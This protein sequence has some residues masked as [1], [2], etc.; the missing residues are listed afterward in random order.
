MKVVREHLQGILKDAHAL[1]Q[2]LGSNPLGQ[3]LGSVAQQASGLNQVSQQMKRTASATQQLQSTLRPVRDEF[4]ALRAEAHNIDFGDLTDTQQFK[5]AEREIDSY[6][7]SLKR[8]E[9]QVDK[10]SPQGRELA[11]QLQ[12]QQT[13]ASNR[14]G[15]ATQERRSA[16]AQQRQGAA[17]A[18]AA[19]GAAVM[20]PI[21]SIGKEAISVTA[22]F[23]DQ[24]AAIKAVLDPKDWGMLDA[25]RQKSKDLGAS[26]RFSASDAA[27][28]FVLLAQ[29]GY[30]V[31]KQMAAITGTL[32]L[33]AAGNLELTRA[34]EITVST[35]GQFQLEADRATHVAN[36]LAKAAAMGQIDVNDMGESLKYTGGS[37]KRANL[38][39]EQTSALLALL[40][41]GGLK[42][43]M[44]GSN[45]GSLIDSLTAPNTLGAK[46]I[47]ELGV[48]TK[49]ARGNLL[50]FEQ[51]LGQVQARISKLPT[52]KQNNLMSR[53]FGVTGSRAASIL[54]PRFER[55]ATTT[56][57]I[58][59]SA[60]KGL[61]AA[62]DQATIME[63]DIGGSFRSFQSAMEGVFIE[64]GEVLVPI[65][66]AA[67]D[68][69][70]ALLG[71]FISLPKPIKTAIVAAGLVTLGIATLAIVVGTA[72]F[73]FFG[74]Q[75]A[76][77]QSAIAMTAMASKGIPLTGF[78]A[79]AM[80][81]FTGQGIV[82]GFGALATG[83][84]DAAIALGAFATGPL[85]LAIGAGIAIIALLEV[86]T[87]GFNVLGTVI[88]AVLAPVAVIFGVIKG[89]LQGLAVAFKP[90]LDE[91]KGLGGTG[92]YLNDVFKTAIATFQTFI[93]IGQAVGSALGLVL[94]VVIATPIRLL[95][96]LFQFLSTTLSGLGTI[97]S[98]I[99]NPFVGAA[100]QIRQAWQGFVDWFQAMP[101]VQFALTVGQGLINALNH[102]PTIV[103]PASWQGAIDSI[104][105]F[106]KPLMDFAQQT[107]QFLATVLNPGQL[108]G[109]LV[110]GLV[111][112]L[113]QLVQAVQNSGVGK[114]FWGATES[115]QAFMTQ[116][117]QPLTVPITAQV[118]PEQPERYPLAT[119]PG[120][121]PP[122]PSP[123]A[124]LPVSPVSAAVMPDLLMS[125]PAR[126]IQTEMQQAIAV[127][128]LQAS[129]GINQSFDTI[130]TEWRQ[131]WSYLRATGNTDAA[132]LFQP[133]LTA[134]KD[135]LATVHGA[136]GSTITDMA[137]A[138]ATLD[139][140]KAK[141]SA[142]TLGTTL[143]VG[144]DAAGA[145]MG[146][147]TLSAMVL[148]ASSL[149][150]L[151]P[152]VLLLGGVAL[153]ALAISTNFLGIRT[154]LM[155]IVKIVQGAIEIVRGLWASFTAI[156]GTVI[157][158]GQGIRQVFGGILPALQGDFSGIR[159][160]FST[161]LG[162]MQAGASATAQGIR[163]SFGGVARIFEGVGQVGRGVFVGLRQ[164]VQGVA[165]AISLAFRSARAGVD[166]FFQGVRLVANGFQRLQTIP[167]LVAGMGD[168]LQATWQGLSQ[169]LNNI[170]ILR[171]FVSLVASLPTVVTREVSRIQALWSG[172][173]DR[174][175]ATWQGT[176][177]TINNIPVL[178]GFIG[179]V[180]AFPGQ[181]GGVLQK[182]Q[183]LWSGMSDRLTAIWQGTV[184][185]L[186][187]IP[188]LRGLVA[189]LESLP[190]LV[191]GTVERVQATWHGAITALDNVPVLRGFVTF[192]ETLP[193][194]VSGVI[195][196]VQSL[197]S[198]MGDRLGSVFGFLQGKSKQTGE[199]L[200]SN[201][202]ENSPGPTFMIRQKWSLLAEVLEGKLAAIAG[203]A[204]T[205]G[206]KITGSLSGEKI[207]QGVSKLGN[208][209]SSVG[210][211]L[212]NFAPQLAGPLFLVGDIASSFDTLS[213]TLPGAQKLLAKVGPQLQSL[214]GAGALIPG[215]LGTIGTAFSGMATTAIAAFGSVLLPILPVLAVIAGIVAAV[216]LLRQAFK[217]NFL[218][219]RTLVMGV[220]G[221]ISQIA[222]TMIAPFVF[223][224]QMV[225]QV[226]KS[227]IDSIAGFFTSLLDSARQTGQLILNVLNPARLFQP[228]I[229]GLAS[230]LQQLLDAISN[231]G[232]G[233]VLNKLG[234]GGLTDGLQGFVG[235]L[236]QGNA[237]VK[238]IAKAP[239]AP[240]TMTS[241]TTIAQ[242]LVQGVQQGVS[243]AQQVATAG[244]EQISHEWR[245]HWSELDQPMALPAPSVNQWN[246]I[247]QPVNVVLPQTSVGE[248]ATVKTQL[249]AVQG[250]AGLLAQ[251]TEAA[252]TQSHFDG[253]KQSVSSFGEVFTQT[254]HGILG[255]FRSM[256]LGAIVF[257]VSSLLSVSP[258]I[259]ILGGMVLATIALATNFLGLRTILVGVGRV[260]VG[261][262]Q[263]VA[264]WIRGTAGVVQGLGNLIGGVFAAIRGDFS[265][266]RL[267]ATQV[268]HGIKTVFT[269]TATGLQT[270]F[271]GAIQIIKGLFQG[272]GQVVQ[273]IGL[274]LKGIGGT[275]QL[276][277][278]TLAGAIALPQKIW[279][280]FF[281]LLER[282]QS[283]V[284]GVISAVQNSSVGK[285][286]AAV[287]I[288]TQ[289]KAGTMADAVQLAEF[290]QRLQSDQTPAVSGQRRGL[291]GRLFGRKELAGTAN[292]IAQPIVIPAPSVPVSLS[293]IAPT[294]PLPALVQPIAVT[295]ATVAPTA[296]AA[297]IEQGQR[298]LQQ[299]KQQRQEAV[300]G[301]STSVSALGNVASLMAP[302]IAA[303]VMAA[304][305]LFDSFVSLG[306]AIPQVTM[307][308]GGLIPG[309]LGTGTAAVTAG[310]Q[311]ATGAAIGSTATATGA[312]VVAGANATMGFSFGA[313]AT[314]AG[315][316]WTAITGPLLPLLLG[317]G[318]AVAAVGLLWKAFDSNFLGI[319][320]TVM[321]VWQ[322]ITQIVGDVWQSF[323]GIFSSL[324]EAVTQVGSAIASAFAPLLGNGGGGAMQ[325]AIKAMLFPL[326]VVSTVLKVIFQI[327]GQLIRVV[328]T[329]L[330]PMIQ[331]LIFPVRLAA[332][333]L[334]GVFTTISTIAGAVSSIFGGIM[335][336]VG[337]VFQMLW[338]ALPAPIRWLIQMASQGMGAIGSFVFGA[339]NAPQPP[340]I[341][342]FAAGGLVQ[343]PG[344]ATSDSIPALLSNHEYVMPADVTQRNLGTLEAM[345]SGA[346]IAAQPQLMPL[347]LPPIPP[348]TPTG[349]GGSIEI[350]VQA[351][352]TIEGGLTVQGATP[353]LAAEDLVRQVFDLAGPML[354]Q[355]VVDAM[356]RRVEMA[357]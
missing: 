7:Q 202:A 242:P 344:T 79:N 224:A 159:Q 30:D 124:P 139:F 312:G 162:A 356:R 293:S 81:A 197:W 23:N 91:F 1:K 231:S 112:R 45:L 126:Q 213:E 237:A 308:L 47:Q 41:E 135:S 226:W 103:I 343:G 338:S 83:I 199:A 228:L 88:G 337:S 250:E 43:E 349:G 129:T 116:L 270:V 239:I 32:N 307:L 140:E 232:L 219:I 257:G 17:G 348:L 233:A 95:I 215:L 246:P 184:N 99:A 294:Q 247:E 282:V 287:G 51:I 311:Q 206:Q 223:A 316:A 28:G 196:K 193:P 148:G 314:A 62:K 318:L 69:L 89:F 13:I 165:T 39:L 323:S 21:V 353:T 56:Q 154:I 61:G 36:V 354:E 238:E 110:E 214:R 240:P 347:P 72:S 119:M 189:F 285:M 27:S 133:G 222:T 146:S 336:T 267:G 201:L 85:G 305:T 261:L 19:G 260:A 334:Q 346:T 40:S 125:E 48:Q 167:S 234:L 265:Q 227:G 182:V 241:A 185:A 10:T 37:A 258:L 333:I 156:V 82:A 117:S 63:G 60:D 331:V 87:P 120:N 9:T 210:V 351:P 180:E 243:Q 245:N 272:L 70:S 86:L 186:N 78:F 101:L 183:A 31:D 175:T 64:I 122:P 341:Q 255:G 34:T 194:L 207:R 155:G 342:Q 216:F 335:N 306:Q 75:A 244:L 102:N 49:D 8:L 292:A 277:G 190:T 275:A 59:D 168:R 212:S 109:G 266:M 24:I 179:L 218:G 113:Q 211:V 90:V 153:T 313:L 259:L 93:P 164:L 16:I 208:S 35:L 355:M 274:T 96:K 262:F 134:L 157:K 94:G 97:A 188:V 322:S 253:L 332:T 84:G 76:M 104:M 229:Q 127:V 200:I 304:S 221:S 149:L 309:F 46:A 284:Q 170:P 12:R 15:T 171:G 191:S 268:G 108:F 319:R 143:K 105:G 29:A 20:L 14:V 280:G 160:G 278:Q 269:G 317:I 145:A 111:S 357:R 107:G 217:H 195:Q 3:M 225:Q 320:D 310:A 58:I 115:L 163:R 98:T 33:A 325:G 249:Q 178:R 176:L 142:Q 297:S 5:R 152:V 4:R 251:Q 295:S 80:S 65:V 203:H 288:R 50:P 187:N 273:G 132:S 326:Q 151:S 181:V 131:R 256:G 57:T 315:A 144:L 136:V 130:T 67:T 301:V 147:L 71:M 100:T 271:G 205:T 329:A 158:V 11:A 174:L 328:A 25:I 73:A 290:D 121:P 74:L 248:L 350:T 198:G 68:R 52:G 352:I 118:I 42:G 192:I 22:N 264:A 114:L 6:V 141:A 128:S 2:E 77:A 303:P 279:A 53:I 299:Q 252:L 150:S 230:K 161:M 340:P 123:P 289:G 339:G 235:Q 286:A 236:Q 296:Q 263:M 138:I 92:G 177:T 283:K 281:D 38:S 166:F 66:K 173:S 18:V 276:L 26:T 55:F 345:R 321:G 330:T 209:F 106:F 324:W 291:M 204:R 172:M 169:T 254:T 302:T 298:L 44:A 327:L 54:L 137:A 300:S 220:V